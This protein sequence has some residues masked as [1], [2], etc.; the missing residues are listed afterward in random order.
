VLR[1]LKA[2]GFLADAPVN[3]WVLKRDLKACH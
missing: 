1:S 2:A 3:Y